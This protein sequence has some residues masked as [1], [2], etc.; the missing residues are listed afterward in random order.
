[1]TALLSFT[2]FTRFPVTGLPP[3]LNVNAPSD[4]R[5][6]R[7]IIVSFIAFASQF[8]GKVYGNG[9]RNVTIWV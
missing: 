5:R 7:V 1:M 6:A 9:L 8:C 3:Y 4:A 2:K